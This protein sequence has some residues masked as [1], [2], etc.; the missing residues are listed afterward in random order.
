MLYASLPSEI[1]AISFRTSSDATS[2]TQPE[3]LPPSPPSPEQEES[4]CGHI[5]I[6]WSGCFSIP[7]LTWVTDVPCRIDTQLHIVGTYEHGRGRHGRKQWF[8]S[9]KTS[10]FTWEFASQVDI[11][12]PHKCTQH[13]PDAARCAYSSVI[14]THFRKEVSLTL[15]RPPNV[16]SPSPVP[17]LTSTSHRAF[18]LVADVADCRPVVLRKTCCFFLCSSQVRNFSCSAWNS[19][20]TSP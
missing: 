19:L 5:A 7:S 9:K 16:L 3:L 18:E 8:K 13:P 20:T 14:P 15:H 4:V 1:H 11:I 10:N 17:T 2:F 6:Q 12:F